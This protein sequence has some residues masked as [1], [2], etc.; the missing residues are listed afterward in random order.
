MT[1]KSQATTKALQ[2][3]ARRSCPTNET[4]GVVWQLRLAGNHGGRTNYC[5]AAFLAAQ[6][7]FNLAESLALAAGLILPLAFRVAGLAAGATPLILAQRA[8]AALEI[9]A[10]AAALM[11][12]F[13]FLPAGRATDAAGEPSNWISSFSSAWIRSFNVAAL[14]NC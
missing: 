13:F 11:V 2:S 4:A 1:T 9:L 14:R 6:I 7:A 12:N 5:C 8:L 3:R 10:L